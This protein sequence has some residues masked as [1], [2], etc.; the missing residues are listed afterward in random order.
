MSE[1]KRYCY[2]ESNWEEDDVIVEEKLTEK[3]LIFME[4]QKSIC[5]IQ[6]KRKQIEDNFRVITI[7]Q[8]ELDSLLRKIDKQQKR[9]MLFLKE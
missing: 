2:N 4:I 8:K 6:F 3:E 7:H 9:L 5:L 1:V